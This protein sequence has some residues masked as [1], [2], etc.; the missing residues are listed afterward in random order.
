[1]VRCVARE[2][3]EWS[4]VDAQRLVDLLVERAL[5]EI[6][7]YYYYTLLR[8]HLVGVKGDAL[9]RVVDDA[10]EEDRNHFEA[11]V[12]RIYELGGRL[13]AIFAGEL[14]GLGALRNLPAEADVPQIIPIL[15]KATEESVRAYTQL[16]SAT[17][18][19]D[20]RTYNLVLAILHEEIAHQVWLLEFLGR[21]ASDGAA[22]P[23]DIS[24]F[25]A[26]HLRPPQSA[27]LEPSSRT[28]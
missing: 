4:G 12:P 26:P 18:G 7:N 14:G 28:A 20:N 8:M 17:A 24:P 21:D 5:G 25:V 19:K 22:C 9:R 6:G 1:M 3:V 23:R 15:L 16:C 27:H 11:L 2:L 13:P 10:R